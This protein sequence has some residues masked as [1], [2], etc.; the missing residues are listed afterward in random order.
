VGMAATSDDRGYWVAAADGTVFPFGD[1]P[2]EGNAAV[3]HPVVG[4]SASGSGYRL[5]SSDGGIFTFGSASFSGSAGSM[6]LNQPMIG[7]STTSTGYVTVA[8]DGGIFTY[9]SAGFY[10]S[11][12][13]STVARGSTVAGGGSGAAGGS[14]AE[15]DG[16][17]PQQ[18]AAWYRVNLCEEGGVWNV[19]GPVYSGGLGFSHS[20]WD[21]FN[22]FGFPADA[23]EATPDQQIR[24]A[25][26]FATALWGNPDAAPDQ[27]GCAG[28][29]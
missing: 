17:T 24:V 21:R 8:A 15:G 20:N 19:N 11:L 1:A 13:G 29:Y 26:A 7:I 28:G 25:V 16:I 18:R 9:G 3:G 10:G 4:I 5:V 6:T 14:G 2:A 27:D 23:A 12:G 22:A